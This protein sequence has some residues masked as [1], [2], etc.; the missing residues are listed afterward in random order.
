MGKAVLKK[1]RNCILGAIILVGAA[2]IVGGMTDIVPA[3][4]WEPLAE[5]FSARFRVAFC[6]RRLVRAC[7]GRRSPHTL[8]DAGT[9]AFVLLFD[10]AAA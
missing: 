2:I 5:F 10:A 6:L 7:P 1:I 4:T 8:W 3:V 9:V